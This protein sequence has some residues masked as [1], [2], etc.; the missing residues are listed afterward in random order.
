MGELPKLCIYIYPPGGR[1]G[2]VEAVFRVVC[3]ACIN[4][5][6]RLSGP[7]HLVV[8]KPMQETAPLIRI[9]L[10]L[11]HHI[12]IPASARRRNDILVERKRDEDNDGDEIDGGAHGAHAL[13]QLRAVD[14]P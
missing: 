2:G 5:Q 13:G 10:H 12:A 3:D 4:C 11:N 9:P 7:S 1:G 14:F 6:T 8:R